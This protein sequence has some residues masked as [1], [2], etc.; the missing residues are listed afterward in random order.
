M[1]PGDPARMMLDQREDA[2]QLMATDPDLK[3]SP[4]LLAAIEE[5][6]AEPAQNLAKT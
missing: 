1:L 3:K 4:N 6:E 2:E 5:F